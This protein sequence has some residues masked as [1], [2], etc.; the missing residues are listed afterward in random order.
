VISAAIT[1]ATE[2]QNRCHKC[3]APVLTACENCNHRLRGHPSGVG[4]ILS[5]PDFCDNC[6]APHP[7][8]SRE[9]RIFMLQNLLDEEQLDPATELEV[10]EQLKALTNPDLD[11]DEQQ[12]RWA[13]VKRLAPG[14]WERTGARTILESVVS[15]G[16][17]AGLG[18]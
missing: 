9:G 12:R 6:G 7:W 4:G 11:A 8:L 10:R 5:V 15:A 17:K 2:L 14:L 3:G 1:P 18:L 16:I 13:T